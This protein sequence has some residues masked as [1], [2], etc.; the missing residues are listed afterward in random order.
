MSVRFRADQALIVYKFPSG[1]EA[2]AK[3]KKCIKGESSANSTKDFTMASPFSNQLVD[4]RPLKSTRVELSKDEDLVVHVSE[5]ANVF[6]DSSDAD[7]DDKSDSDNCSRQYD[8]T[9]SDLKK[10]K[11]KLE[12]KLKR[13]KEMVSSLELKLAQEEAKHENLVQIMKLLANQGGILGTDDIDQI[14]KE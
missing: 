1:K 13:T 10:K 9:I 3:S 14:P 12:E 8:K 7:S 4:S 6:S 11:A 2:M 5:D